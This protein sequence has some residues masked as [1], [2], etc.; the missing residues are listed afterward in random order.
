LTAR[1]ARQPRVVVDGRLLRSNRAGIGRY[2]RH[3]YRAVAALEDAGQAPPGMAS[4]REEITVLYSRRDDERALAAA[5]PRA[6]AA[7]TPAHHRLERWALALEGARLLPRLWHAPDHVCPQPLGWRTVLTVHDLAF[8]R[9]PETH[10]PESRAYYAGLWRSARQAT[11]IICVSQATRLDLLQAT[12]VPAEKVRVVYEAPDPR[13]LVAGEAPR[14]GPAPP[15]GRAYVL[16]V[17]T[18]EPRKNLGT[19]FRALGRLPRDGRPEVRVVGAPGHGASAITALPA[20]LGLGEDARFLCPRPTDEVA[21]LYRGA[22]A[23][24]Y[25]SLWEGF[26]LPV[27]E[28]MAA[29][30]PVIASARSSIPEV[31]GE[32]AL[33]VDP[34]DEVALAGALERVASSPAL[35]DELRRKGQAR[36]TRFTWERAARETLDVF[37][38][39]IEEG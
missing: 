9:H 27:L 15:A 38:E 39:A 34:E 33:L 22:L 32:A 3:L 36:A 25:P 29:G 7:W 10:A 23:L 16:C 35:R 13:Y 2:L 26:G 18:V 24:V 28:A 30:A 14:A 6:A 19:L 20:R 5:L 12:G 11:R 21:A 1:R 37:V 4:P 31:A 17:G 8:W